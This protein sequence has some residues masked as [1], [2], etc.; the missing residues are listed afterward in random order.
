MRKTFIFLTT[1]CVLSMIGCNPYPPM[2][3]RNDAKDA[4]EEKVVED[5]TTLTFDAEILSIEDFSYVV[6]PVEG[7]EE[8]N[9]ADMIVVSMQNTDRPINPGLGD[10]IRIVYDGTIEESY[11][12]QIHNVYSIRVVKEKENVMVEGP[13]LMLM[14]DGQLYYANGKSSDQK[15]RCGIVDGVVDTT[16]EENQ[17]P[18][19][20]N[21]SNFGVGYQYQT[22]VE[23]GTI[24]VLIDG[25]WWIFE[26]K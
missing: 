22:G 21:E 6:K 1:L 15:E 14:V 5:M 23:I 7:S 9:S 12:A 25:E 20:N 16:V 26:E 4:T 8:L 10:I 13:S 19:K 17:I 2:S 3:E 24:D 11:P 18:T